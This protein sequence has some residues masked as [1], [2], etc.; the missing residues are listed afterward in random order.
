MHA[1]AGY[2][3]GAFTLVEAIQVRLGLE[4]VGIQTLLAQL[5]VGL[6]VVSE[7]LDFQVHTFLGQR[8]LDQF[9]DFRMRYGRCAD[10]QLF[11]CVSQ[12]NGEHSRQSG[13]QKR[14]FH[15]MS[16]TKSES[17]IQKMTPYYSMICHSYP[18]PATSC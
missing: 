14:L 12:A 1:N 17:V 7:D 13:Q 11:T 10:D 2:Q 8:R 15:A 18:N 4:V 16:L 6:Y 9:E 5:D 3:V